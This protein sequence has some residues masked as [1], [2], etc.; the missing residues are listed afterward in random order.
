MGNGH[1]PPLQLRTGR[2]KL[3]MHCHRLVHTGATKEGDHAYVW[4]KG[5]CV[6]GR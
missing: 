6:L 4:Y 3:Q 1:P 5:V 2:F